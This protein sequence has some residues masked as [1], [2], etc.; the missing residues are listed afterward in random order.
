MPATRSKPGPGLT[1]AT[2]S[3]LNELTIRRPG[4]RALTPAQE[5]AYLLLCVAAERLRKNDLP[6][7]EAMHGQACAMDEMHNG[8]PVVLTAAYDLIQ[9]ILRNEIV[10]AN[11]KCTCWL[12]AAQRAYQIRNTVSQAILTH[13]MLA[14]ASHE[15]VTA[16]A[17]RQIR[18]Q[19]GTRRSELSPKALTRA[20]PSM[21]TLIDAAV[22]GAVM[23]AALIQD[24]LDMAGMG[25][26]LHD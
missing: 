24:I 5:Q 6:A 3:G 22:T 10:D 26:F 8:A 18:L 21:P 25:P 7:V 14:V 1:D 15:M 13:S 12:T 17:R 9:T 19:F 20:V 4:S 2:G 16:Q 23:A 11:G